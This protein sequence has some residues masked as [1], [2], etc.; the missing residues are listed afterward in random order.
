VH[1]SEKYGKLSLAES[2]APAIRYARQGMRLAR[3][4]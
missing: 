1:L 2:L 3:G 4:T